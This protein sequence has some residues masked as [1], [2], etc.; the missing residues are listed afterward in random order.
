VRGDTE[1]VRSIFAASNTCVGFLAIQ[2]EGTGA[3]S[4]AC[5]TIFSFFYYN[6]QGFMKVTFASKVVYNFAPL[7]NVLNNFV[8]IA[9]FF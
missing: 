6:L 3:L 4:I 7:I 2:T 5:P 8:V 9:N 1:S